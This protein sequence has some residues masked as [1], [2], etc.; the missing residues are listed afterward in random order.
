M[1][2]PLT[3]FNNAFI[4]Q[5]VDS[6]KT[7]TEGLKEITALYPRLSQDDALEGESNSISNQKKILAKYAFDHGLNNCVF[8][9]DDGISG[10]TFD[11]PGFNHM[12]ADVE[13]GR[14]KN[15]VVKDMS[16]FGR[17]YLK[18]GYF[19]EVLFP[20]MDVRFIAINDGVDSD[21]GDN[22]YMPFKNLFNEWYARDTSRKI[23]AVNR[24]K[25][26]AGEKLCTRAPYGYLKDPE[27]KKQWIIDPEASEVVKKIFCYCIGGYGPTQIARMLR[28]EKVLS[29]GH[30]LSAK[31]LKPASFLT[32]DPFGWDTAT[33]RK[34][35]ARMEYLGHTVNFKTYKKSYKSKKTLYNDPS[36]WKIFKDTHPAIID[37]E[38]FDRVQEIREG[39]RRNTAT[40]KVGL[41]SGI[42]HC[43]DCGSKM[44]YCTSKSI[45]REQEN[46]VC[47]G[48]RGKKVD[49][50]SSHYIRLVV[51]EQVVLADLKRVMSFVAKYED[52]FIALTKQKAEMQSGKEIN[53]NR[54][55][56]EKSK[57]RTGELDKIIQRLYEDNVLGK[58]TDDRFM[59]LSYGYEQEQEK[60]QELI[61]EL[62]QQIGQQERKAV[63]VEKF[64]QTA[65]RY[66]DI[67]ELTPTIVNELIDR[68][69]IHKRDK[70]HSKK[71]VQQIDIHYNFIGVVG[72]LDIENVVTALPKKEKKKAT[73]TTVVA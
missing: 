26:N 19:T 71:A 39:R 4:E 52:Q 21:G 30:H 23:T 11:R 16:R 35:L 6:A 73:S 27:N 25:G 50:D 65:K 67:T 12:I 28:E 68:I 10:T 70:R 49:C 32:R 29:P 7:P 24:L 5:I 40:G 9:V 22:D 54:K 15:L 8:Y 38:T 63:S 59:K 31:G 61:A 43:A 48:F 53:M 58:L 33:V 36:N 37:Q 3:T 46:Y 55:L 20:E 57:A 47:S 14:V 66:T 62:E 45:T 2:N 42:A 51:L 34:I 1:K 18:V 64:L 13:A 69:D 72:E 44:Y 17:D 56:L 41:F 60:L